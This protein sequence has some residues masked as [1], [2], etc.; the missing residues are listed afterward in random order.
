MHI[1][2]YLVAALVV[3]YLGSK[4]GGS[5]IPAIEAEVNKIEATASA[6]AKAL[7]AKIKTLL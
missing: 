6:D 7:A 1:V 3:F 4:F 5:A 2:I